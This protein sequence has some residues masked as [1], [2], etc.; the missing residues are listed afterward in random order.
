MG[1]DEIVLDDL[2]D[3]W[4]LKAQIRSLAYMLSDDPSAGIPHVSCKEVR[5][6]AGKI[7]ELQAFR[8]KSELA[9]LSLLTRAFTDLSGEKPTP[10]EARRIDK[11]VLENRKQEMS[12]QTNRIQLQHNPEI[13]EQMTI[14]VFSCAR[15]GQDHQATFQRF[16][17]EPILITENTETKAYNWFALCPVVGDPILMT[18]YEVQK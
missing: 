4:L 5:Y 16:Q 10:D 14:S 13:A 11:L 6:I 7:K 1:A 12:N 8:S 18:V 3:L 2:N 15:C 9:E 17:G